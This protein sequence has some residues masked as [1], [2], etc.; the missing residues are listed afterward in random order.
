MH[1]IY[2]CNIKQVMLTEFKK[3]LDGYLTAEP[4]DAFTPYCEM[5]YEAFSDSFYER[6]YETN[7]LVGIGFPN[8]NLETKWLEKVF[9]KGLE[10]K[11]GAKIIE[12]AYTFFIEL[13]KESYE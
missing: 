10:P 4:E 12:R 3:S 5:V 9:R 1:C 7:L 6:V 2:I 13:K 11:L 8:S